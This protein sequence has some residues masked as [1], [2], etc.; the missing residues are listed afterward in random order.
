M[1][2]NQHNQSRIEHLPIAFFSM[3]M[4]LAGFT[5]AWER[6]AEIFAPGSSATDVLA[7][8]TAAVFTLLL[9]AYMLK[10]AR[11]PAAVNQEFRHPVKL[12]FFP[13]VS[14]SMLLLS[15]VVLP[16]EPRAAETLWV[17][18]VVWH[19]A[20]TLYVVNA[21]IHHEH[22]RVEH[23]NPAWFI[24][25]VGN[26]VIPIT[27]MPL[28]YA[29]VSWF[30]F[31]VGMM[32]WGILFVIVFYRL[33]F[34]AP[35]DEKLMPTLFIL[36][37]PPA[38]GF[39]AYSK[40]TGDLDTFARFLYYSGLFLT[41]L[42]LTQVSRFARLKFSL[43]WWAYSF[44]LAAISIASLIMY[45][46]TASAVYLWIGSALLTLLTALIVMLLFRTAVAVRRHGICVPE[47]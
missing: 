45:T 20:L 15:I 24:P 32:F 16:A 8:I 26:V 3:V 25:A 19:L 39:I 30:F 43:S 29:D 42:L 27:G 6:A 18:G 44:P 35:I 7:L 9:A 41:I 2:S 46:G 1:E 12:N 23:I 4:G 28:G 47:Q 31:S 34:H 22:F 37:A 17:L 14:I 13:T 36:I 10:L 11:H 40:L 21:W 33:M 5:I 38:V